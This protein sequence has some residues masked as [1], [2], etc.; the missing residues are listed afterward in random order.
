MT[1]SSTRPAGDRQGDD[2]RQRFAEQVAGYEP[3]IIRIRAGL[4][5]Q[6]RSS[7][8]SGRRVPQRPVIVAS[9][10]ATTAAAAIAM[11][12]LLNRPTGG[13]V[14]SVAPGPTVSI[15]GTEADQ[16]VVSET[17]IRLPTTIPTAPSTSSEPSETEVTPPPAS[18]T[19]AMTLAPGSSPSTNPPAIR[20]SVAE[21][22]GSLSLGPDDYLDWTIA[23]SRDDGK[24]IRLDHR[25]PIISVRAQGDP[26]DRVSAPIDIVWTDGHPEEDRAENGHWWSVPA[27][28]EAFE[29][30]VAGDENPAEIA[31][32]AGGTTMVTAT[33][34]VGG[35]SYQ[36]KL[37]AAAG[38]SGSAGVVVVQIDAAARGSDITI[39]LGGEPGT[40]SVAL[41]AV[42]LR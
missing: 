23:G 22:P 26:P 1:G 16:P 10:G 25:D 42:A 30:A 5:S 2:L 19:T 38:D 34:A 20:M 3:D 13:Q 24:L 29:L 18:E 4:E 7:S 37:P 36:I 33:V 12:A 27:T 31:V 15:A 17:S 32:Y 11:V 28:A 9:L 39:V 14:S 40:G 41:G 6:R 8:R 21:L 35:E